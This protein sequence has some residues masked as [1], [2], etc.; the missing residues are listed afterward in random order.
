MPK[1]LLSSVLY[2]SPVLLIL[3]ACPIGNSGGL[4]TSANHEGWALKDER[5]EGLLVPELKKCWLSCQGCQDLQIPVAKAKRHICEALLHPEQLS[6]MQEPGTRHF[7]ATWVL[8]GVTIHG[9]SP[10][11]LAAQWLA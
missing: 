5:E 11:Y 10:C 2:E 3:Q 7:L 1:G 6:S 9:F 8:M 4:E